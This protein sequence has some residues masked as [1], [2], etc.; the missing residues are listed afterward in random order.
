MNWGIPEETYSPVIAPDY[1]ADR[2]RGLGLPMHNCPS[3]NRL[4]SLDAPTGNRGLAVEKTTDSEEDR[5]RRRAREN[6]RRAR[7]REIA[8]LEREML[9]GDRKA[10]TLRR[11]LVEDK[12][13]MAYLKETGRTHLVETR[14]LPF[15]IESGQS[16]RRAS[17]RSI[18][19]K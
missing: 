3:W 17:I 4:T 9:M 6:A 10:E 1:G 16:P 19:A 18:S 8:R 14:P 11:K 13:R 7:D 15:T 2:N 5:L 12:A